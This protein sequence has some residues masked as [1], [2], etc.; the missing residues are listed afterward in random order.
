MAEHLKLAKKG[1]TSADGLFLAKE[2]GFVPLRFYL[3]KSRH[4]EQESVMEAG[5]TETLTLKRS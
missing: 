5:L 1:R 4:L 3:L 2:K